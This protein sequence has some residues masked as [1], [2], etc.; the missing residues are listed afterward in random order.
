MDLYEVSY[1]KS[2]ELRL[3]EM[4]TRL[5]S[6]DTPGLTQ[7][8]PVAGV[9]QSYNSLA[10]E[11]PPIDPMHWQYSFY[12]STTYPPEIQTP[13]EHS[14]L[15][16]TGINPHSSHVSAYSG[17]TPNA[18]IPTH[19]S[20]FFVLDPVAESSHKNDRP[21]QGLSISQAETAGFLHA[22]FERIH[23]RYPF[24]D[25]NECSSAY[26]YYKQMS[27]VADGVQASWYSFLLTTVSS[28]TTLPV[29][30]ARLNDSSCVQLGV[31]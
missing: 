24:L 4:E 17:A 9:Q 3:A 6:Q 15:D 5:Q 7:G 21:L 1:V 29:G 16:S 12:S 25:I 19:D 18:T 28:S 14:F 2:L 11:M 10:D 27:T 20:D 23:P 31:Q 22:Y 8:F 26:M 30:L 13:L